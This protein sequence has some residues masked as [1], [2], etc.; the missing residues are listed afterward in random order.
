[1][2]SKFKGIRDEALVLKYKDS[3]DDDIEMEL[4]ARYKIHSRK[5]A[6][7]LYNNF[8]YVF[9]VEYEDIFSIALANLFVAIK[10]FKT[11]LSFFKLWKRIATN[12]VKIYVT[13][14]P[15]LSLHS[16]TDFFSTSRD[17]D[18]NSNTMLLTSPLYEDNSVLSQEIEKL[19]V[20]NKA[21]N[22]IHDR[23]IYVL[24]VSGFTVMD[25]ANETGLKYHYVR[26]RVESIKRRIKKYF[27]HS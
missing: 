19:L 1:M 18:L 13:T 14:L 12:E 21:K 23:D 8:K 7:E 11:E 10:S 6:G 16:N 15:L 5:L 2:L 25:I 24:Y 3:R 27:V 26:S 20:S 17:N 22:S 4:I 9:Q